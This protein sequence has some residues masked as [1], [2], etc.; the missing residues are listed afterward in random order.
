[1]P[2]T[3]PLTAQAVDVAHAVGEEALLA[4]ALYAHGF[5]LWRAG[6]RAEALPVMEEAAA[7]AEAAGALDVLSL[8]LAWLGTLYM[9]RR[10]AAPARECLD[11]ALEVAERPDD[12]NN[13]MFAVQ[14]R[15]T[16]AGLSGDG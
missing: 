5:A 8:A 9:S 12:P 2:E 15:S 1:E 4:E 14:V 7:R 13:I 11:R 3:V 10:E 16:L 6:R